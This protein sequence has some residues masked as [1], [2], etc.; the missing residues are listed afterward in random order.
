MGRKPDMFPS[1]DLSLDVIVPAYNEEAVIEAFHSQLMQVL[2]QLP[3]EKTVYYVDDGSTDQTLPLLEQLA[4]RDRNVVV[5][6]L[7]RNFGHQ[8]ALSAGLEICCGDVVIT[9]DADGQHPPHMIP[10]MISLYQSGYEIVLTKRREVEG[11]SWFKRFTSNIF[12]R[13]INRFSNTRMVPAAADFRLLSRNVVDE[14]AK[15]Q[16]YHR[17]LRGMVAWMGYRSIVLP[18]TPPRRM[19]G[20]SKYSFRKM[21]K[22]AQDA[23]FSFSLIPLYMGVLLGI[24]FLLMAFAESIYV[25]SFWIRGQQDQLVRGWSSL[26]FIL[27]IVGGTISTILGI[28]GIY[29]GYI[30]QEVK[31]RP[32]YLVRAIHSHDQQE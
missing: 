28:I 4:E 7:S 8:A 16:E 29:I 24:F 26:M 6:E 10:E 31:G 15:M 20:E 14:L 12:Y 23:A 32:V 5:I 18:F 19:A 13:L 17:F 11:G 22:L 25:L 30:F 3:V 9:M 27:L 1:T 2:S 21:L